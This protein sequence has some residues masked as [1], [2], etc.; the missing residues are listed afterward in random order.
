MT[1]KQKMSKKQG[2]GEKPFVKPNKYS[3][4]EK[5]YTYLTKTR[6]I[7]PELVK[8]TIKAGAVI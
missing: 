4:N 6:C 2:E 1:A 8:R 3:N 7:D 5:V